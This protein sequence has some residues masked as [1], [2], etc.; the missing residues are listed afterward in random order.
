MLIKK[1][2]EITREEGL[3]ALVK[4]L[5]SRIA[6]RLKK[7]YSVQTV[8]HME[9][10]AWFERRKDEYDRLISAIYPYIHS[11]G[12][13]FDIGANI[14]YFTLL[15]AERVNFRGTAYLFEPV[16]HLAELCKITFKNVSF[17]VNVFDFGLSDRD[18][19]ENIFI[20]NNGNLGW[21]T[22][23]SRKATPDMSTVRIRLKMFD[24]CGI[25]ATPS[26]IKVDVEGAEYQVFRGMLGSL[27]KW[28]P[29]PVILCEVGWGHSHP[30]W[31]EEMRIFTEM[32]RI[33]YT[34]CNL[35]GLQIDERSLQKTTDVLFIPRS[36]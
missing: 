32:K 19:E 26:F 18:A 33:G 6:H 13:I 1:A 15:L 23:V 11:N 24:S 2:M 14:G 9:A 12:I 34:I 30:E 35:D 8:T 25:V 17:D 27:R 7:K 16:V 20:A 5:K 22:L 28:H 31:E 10:L 36:L 21:N 29:L 4:R 3:N